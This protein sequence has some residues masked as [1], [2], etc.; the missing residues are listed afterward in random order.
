MSPLK[1]MDL[2]S[3]KTYKIILMDISDRSLQ[4]WEH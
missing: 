2:E 4:S 1:Y 3:M